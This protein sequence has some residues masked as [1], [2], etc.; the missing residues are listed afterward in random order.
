VVAAQTEPTTRAE[1]ARQTREAILAVALKLF[2]QRGY[3]ATSLQDIADEMG[4]TKAAVYYHYKTKVELLH[5]ICKPVEK[6][7]TA[8]IDTAAQLK[9]RRQKIEAMAN[10]FADVMIGQRD[11]MRVV[12]NDPVMNGEMKVT[13]VDELFDRAVRVLYGDAPTP[14]QILAVHAVASLGDAIATL[15]DLSDDEVRAVLTRALKRLVP[16][17]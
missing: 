14:D 7:M 16:E 10:G 3:D 1:R 6:T 11:V 8:V 5:A 4:L 9:T 17:R 12:A 15:P 2:S 13:R